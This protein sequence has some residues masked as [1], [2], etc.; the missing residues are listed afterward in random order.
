MCSSPLKTHLLLLLFLALPPYSFQFPLQ[1]RILIVA[2]VTIVAI[3]TIVLFLVVII[4]INGSR[5]LQYS[6]P[7][8]IYIFFSA[9]ISVATCGKRSLRSSIA[10]RSLV[11]VLFD[12]ERRA[13]AILLGEMSLLGSK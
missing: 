13:S 6:S 2:V 3:I 1:L 10:S 8:C 11:A 4:R 7:L 12:G 5:L 9:S